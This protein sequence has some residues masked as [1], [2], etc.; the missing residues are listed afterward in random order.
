VGAAL[1]DVDYSANR[2]R[3]LAAG[4][5]ARY[6]LE[7]PSRVLVHARERAERR[8]SGLMEQLAS[9]EELL[10]PRGGGGGA[11]A[12]GG[13]GPATPEL[14]KA[15]LVA[16]SGALIRVAGGPVATLHDETERVRRRFLRALN[17]GAPPPVPA[18]AGDGGGFGGRRRL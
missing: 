13:G 7:L 9:A 10:L 2:V 18:S 16:S 1:G 17:R 12:P 15:T 14:I 3:L 5:H 4:G 11:A 6:D 8:A